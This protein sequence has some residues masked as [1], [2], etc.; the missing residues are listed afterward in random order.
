MAKR[1]TVTDQI[2]EAGAPKGSSLE[3]LIRDNQDYDLLAPEEM[4][5]DYSLPL[6]LRVYW[7]KQHPEIPLPAKN[8]GAAYPEILS[9]LHKRMVANPEQ[10]WGTN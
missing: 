9:Q 1:P 4:N 8:P 6:W 10:P 7:R 3:K 5:D 2:R